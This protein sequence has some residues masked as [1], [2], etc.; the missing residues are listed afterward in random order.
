MASFA[1]QLEQLLRAARAQGLVDSGVVEQLTALAAER[2]RERGWLSLGGVLGRLGA[3]VTIVGFLLL[4]GG[5]HGAGL[6]IQATGRPYPHFAEA[7][8]F[9]GAG[10][11]LGGLALVGQI[12]HLPAN[13]PRAMLV[14]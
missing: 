8:H 10:L 2:E 13:P 4:L 14:W 1:R 5:A 12:Y 7:L 11:F 3:A 6:W 9:L